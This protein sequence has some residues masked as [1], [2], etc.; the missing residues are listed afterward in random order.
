MQWE[1][2]EQRN[3]DKRKTRSGS[4]ADVDEDANEAIEQLPPHKLLD[5]FKKQ[6]VVLHAMLFEGAQSVP[7]PG[8]SSK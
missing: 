5:E 1:A 8:I 7:N 4:Y 2:E 3:R 6:S